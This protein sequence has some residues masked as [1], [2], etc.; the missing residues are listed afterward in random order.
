MPG[1]VGD[2]GLDRAVDLASGHRRGVGAAR[3]DHVDEQVRRHYPD[4]HAGE[5]VDRVDR[6]LAVVEAARAGVVT[7]EADQVVVGEGG[8]DVGADVTIEHLVHVLGG[9]EGAGSDGTWVS[10][11]M[12]LNGPIETR[13][14]SITPN[15]VSS[16]LSILSPNRTEWNMATQIRPSRRSAIRLPTAVT[17]STVGQ[18]SGW[19]SDERGVIPQAR[20]AGKGSRGREHGDCGRCLDTVLPKSAPVRAGRF[21]VQAGER[22]H[23]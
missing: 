2:T 1:V 15:R 20:A 16:I 23:G 5:T 17:S 11:V 7:G 12:V 22:G 13:L 9:T 10:R 19:V 3:A 8:E 6:V 21:G 18:P 14:R 4:L